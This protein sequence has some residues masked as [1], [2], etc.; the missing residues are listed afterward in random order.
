MLKR[1]PGLFGVIGVL[2]EAATGDVDIESED[3]VLSTGSCGGFD[4]I[5]F[6]KVLKAASSSARSARLVCWFRLYL[7]NR[8]ASIPIAINM[9]MVIPAANPPGSVIFS[10]VV[11]FRTG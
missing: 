2:G 4:G 1:M 11:V 6:G 9:R 8:A 10:M 7:V 5:F 3:L